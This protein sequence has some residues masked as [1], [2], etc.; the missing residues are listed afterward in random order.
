MDFS[1]N[2]TQNEVKELANKILTDMVTVDRLNAIDTQEERFD[3]ELWAQL[4]EAGLLG[5]AFSEDNGGMGFGFT[6]LCLFIEETGRTVAPVPVI[7]VIVGAGLPIQQFGDKALAEKLLPEVATGNLIITSAMTEPYNIDAE[8][9][10]TK[11]TKSGESYT[12]SGS[13]TAVVLASQANKLLV[14]ADVDGVT[15]LFLVDS[16]AAGIA[17]TQLGSTSYEPWYEV[18][19]NNTPVEDVICIQEGAATWTE[20]RLQA[21]LCAHQVGVADKSMRIT[22]EFTCERVQFDVPIGSFQ[23]VQHRAADCFIDVTCLQLTTYQAVSLLDADRDATN[24]VMIAKIWAGDTGH[25]VSYAAQ[26][27]HGGTGIDKD[28]HLWRYSL[29]AR[30]NEMLLGSSA[31]LL[32]ALGSRIAEGKAYTE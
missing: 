26:H 7:P 30:Q 6:E 22:A 14:S 13:K 10:Q 23:A 31:E 19:F 11:A 8:N 16:K 20:E 25:R 4:A 28:Y 29:F 32:G 21:A 2:E 27:L 12:L 17:L 9:C 5:V 1:F 15:G 3:S 18:Q 24:E